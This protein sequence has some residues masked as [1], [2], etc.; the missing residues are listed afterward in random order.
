[1]NRHLVSGLAGSPMLAGKPAGASALPAFMGVVDAARDRDVVVLDFAGIEHMTTSYFM[2]GIWPA[3]CPP[4]RRP[5]VCVVVEGASEMV[6]DDLEYGLAF[7]KGGL[8]L[9]VPDDPVRTRILG[10]QFRDPPF[11]ETIDLLLELGAASAVD[12][13]EL[14]PRVQ[15]TAWSN[16]LAA[17]HD[18]GLLKR[19]KVGRRLMYAVVW[20]EE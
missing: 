14:R 7:A 12:L 16:R 2:A 9:V 3:C 20:S 8:W 11:V 10:G 13:N 6:V 4:T 5:D 17:L 18:A 1:M 19:W 15:L